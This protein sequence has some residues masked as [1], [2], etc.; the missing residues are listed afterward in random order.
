MKVF[1]FGIIFL[2]LSAVACSNNNPK[3]PPEGRCITNADCRS[4]NR[5][6][7]SHCEDI[8]HPEAGKTGKSVYY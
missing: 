2:A 5:C 6:N 8:Y 3:L 4:G 7:N 1:S